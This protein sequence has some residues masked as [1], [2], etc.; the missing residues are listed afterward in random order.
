[1][2]TLLRR[3]IRGLACLAAAAMLATPSFADD[4]SP[5]IVDVETAA[6]LLKVCSW[7]ETDPLYERMVSFCLGFVSATAWYDYALNEGDPKRT[8]LCP[9]A[10]TTIT[11]GALQ[12][13]A[14]AKVNPQHQKELAVE[15]VIRSAHEKWGCPEQKKE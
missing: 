4:A 2:R 9:P 7:P 14:W 12:F 10:E 11:D 6:D 5:E 1:M 8:I 15:G 3:P 13:I